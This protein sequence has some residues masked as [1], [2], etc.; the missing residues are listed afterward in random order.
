MEPD[1]IRQSGYNL[2]LH[3]PHRPDDLEHRSPKELVAELIDTER[4]LLK[5]YEDLQREIA[6]FAL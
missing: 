3:N 5:L 4:E 1:P 2:D 6:G